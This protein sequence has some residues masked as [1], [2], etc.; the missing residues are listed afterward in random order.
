MHIGEQRSWSSLTWD[1]RALAAL[2]AAARHEQG[3]LIGKMKAVGFDLRGEAMLQT[4][5]QDLVKIS[6][7]EGENLDTQQ[8]R[9]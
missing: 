5:P 2:R 8:T 1:E 7:I 6:N 9:S 4:L 3:K